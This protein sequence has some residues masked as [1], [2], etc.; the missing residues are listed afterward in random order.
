MMRATRHRPRSWAALLLSATLLTGCSE[1][2]LFGHVAKRVASDDP[3]PIGGGAPNYKVG[4]PY[5]VKG[6]WYYPREDWDYDESGIASW[7]G[8]DFHGKQTAN[9]EIFDQN[10]VSAAHKTLPMPSVVRVTNLDNGRAL[11]IR[12]NDRGPF[13]N[14]RVIDLSRRASQLLGFEGQGTARVRVQL[15][16]E[17]SRA[18]AGKLN[19]TAS[20]REPQVAAAP[21]ENVTAE[22]LPAPGSRE[23]PRTISNGT[24][25]SPAD[26]RTAQAV[27]KAERALAA[28]DVQVVAV[29]STN[30][31]VQAGAFGRHDNALRLQARLSGVGRPVISQ[32]NVKGQTLFRVRFGPLANVEEADRLL[33]SVIAAGQQDARVIVD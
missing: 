28:Q 17:E 32:T 27:E 12:V 13:V 2:N 25:P 9:G 11:V 5:Q 1:M 31:F 4:K 22:T 21:R 18:L 33:E 6:V 15:M 16:P 14:G 24:A 29:R 10:A 23:V 7:Y 20:G 8:P 19:A 30:L 3:P 26:S